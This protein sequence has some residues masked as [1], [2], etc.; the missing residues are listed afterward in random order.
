MQL[1]DDQALGQ[2]SS[3]GSVDS[4][5]DRAIQISQRL[6]DVPIH[7]KCVAQ[8]GDTG[9]TRAILNTAIAPAAGSAQC[10]IAFANRIRLTT[11]HALLLCRVSRH[12]LIIRETCRGL[13]RE[14]Q[15]LVE[16]LADFAKPAHHH[17]LAL[18]MDQVD[19]LVDDSF[20]RQDLARR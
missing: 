7:W 18:Q 6:V 15:L 11:A 19:Q 5:G 2:A 14:L 13:C 17:R 4:L 10:K 12:K 9:A 16:Q 1:R 8:A 3:L 20:I